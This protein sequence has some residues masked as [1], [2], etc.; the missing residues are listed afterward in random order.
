[1]R[2]PIDPQPNRKW[3]AVYRLIF[4]PLEKRDGLG[5]MGPSQSQSS[6]LYHVTHVD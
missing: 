4:A 3:W 1:M 6:I 5:G 2:L